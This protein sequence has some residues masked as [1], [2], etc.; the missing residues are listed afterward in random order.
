MGDVLPWMDVVACGWL[1]LLHTIGSRRN[2][3]DCVSHRS[4]SA[5]FCDRVCLGAGHFLSGDEELREAGRE[6]RID[7]GWVGHPSLDSVFL[8]MSY[9]GTAGVSCT[10]GYMILTSMAVP[11][12]KFG[13][14]VSPSFS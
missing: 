11:L 8:E 3:F 5:T 2:E 1:H 13:K 4:P 6:P 7:G 14:S 12:S 9:Y 10:G